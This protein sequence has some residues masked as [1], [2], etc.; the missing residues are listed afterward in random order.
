MTSGLNITAFGLITAL[1]IMRAGDSPYR[2][3]FAATTAIPALFALP[4]LLTVIRMVFY[5]WVKDKTGE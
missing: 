3:V 4:G 2:Y 1:I 5:F